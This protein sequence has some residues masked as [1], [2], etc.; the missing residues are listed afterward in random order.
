MLHVNSPDPESVDVVLRNGRAA[1]AFGEDLDELELQRVLL[2]KTHTSVLH[3]LQLHVSEGLDS[4]R[5]G[6]IFRVR[7]ETFVMR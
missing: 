7:V 2:P 1:R 5:R 3:R 6:L 4:L